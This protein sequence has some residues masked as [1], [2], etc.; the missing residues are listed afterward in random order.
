MSGVTPLEGMRSPRVPLHPRHEEA[1]E[2]LLGLREDQGSTGRP[3][4]VEGPRDVTALRALGLT[5]PIEV[6]NR[7][8]DVARRIAHLVE[9][10]LSL[11]HI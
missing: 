10:Y 5:G 2:A 8:W 9:T 11:I 1:R 3:I 6:V 4:L 7:G